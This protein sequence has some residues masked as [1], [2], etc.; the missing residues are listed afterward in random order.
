MKKLILKNIQYLVPFIKDPGVTDRAAAF[1]ATRKNC[2]QHNLCRH[3][4]GFW[5][6][7]RESEREKGKETGERGD[8]TQSEGHCDA[9][10]AQSYF[11]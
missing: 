11:L 10:T 6:A 4:Q 8:M 5:S 1:L 7:E 3:L 2:T 9:F